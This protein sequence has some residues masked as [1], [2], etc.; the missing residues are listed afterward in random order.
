MAENALKG[1]DGG[2]LGTV[3]D[4]VGTEE[5]LRTVACMVPKEY[6]E[7]FLDRW[8]GWFGSEGLSFF[9]ITTGLAFS[10]FADCGVDVGVIEAGLGGRLDSTNMITP[11]LAIITSIGLDHCAQLG[12]TLPEIAREKAGIMK[13]GVPCLIGDMNPETWPVFEEMAAT[14]GCPLYCAETMEPPLWDRREEILAGMDLCG[15]YQSKNLRTVL[16]AL[17]LLASVKSPAPPRG[18]SFPCLSVPSSP[19]PLPASWETSLPNDSPSGAQPR[20]AMPPG[21]AGLFTEEAVIDGIC[22]TA[23]RMGFRGR[24]EKLSENPTVICDIAHNPPAL[25]ENFG[26]LSRMLSDGEISSLTIVYGVMADKDTAAIFPLIPQNADLILTAPETPRAMP[27]DELLRRYLSFCASAGRDSSRVRTAP[28]VPEAVSLALASFPAP[29]QGAV[30]LTGVTA[31]GFVNGRGPGLDGTGRGVCSP[32]GT[33]RH[34]RDVPV[35]D[36]APCT[37]QAPEAMV[38]IGG[39]TYVVAE[40]IPLFEKNGL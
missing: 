13:P 26:T 28:S 16:S 3:P 19:E 20:V 21:G 40:A 38:Y 39:S 5:T 10:W 12:S 36:T 25:K 23:A 6:V 35:R 34:G 18:K 27:V 14:V 30:S 33:E 8:E 11:D 4:G 22:H 15:E 2:P 17:G 37:G 29:V 1:P 31:R 24:W 9:E 32:D 7:Q